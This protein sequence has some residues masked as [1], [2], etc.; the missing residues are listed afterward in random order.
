MKR[1]HI[2]LALI[3]ALVTL[4][5]VTCSSDTDR[6]PRSYPGGGDSARG[7]ARADDGLDV[8]PPAD[9][10]HDPQISPA[11]KLSNDQLGALDL[12]GKEQ[13]D[14]IMRLQRDSV[15]AAR[16]VR[17]VVEGNEPSVADITL[18]GQRLRGIR[19]V[20]F[21]R[22]I[23]MLAAERT[24]LTKEQW[25]T[26]Q[27]QIEAARNRSNRNSNGNSGRGRGGMGG[28]GRFPGM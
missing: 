28:R 7:V 5:L 14:E 15:V 23:Q 18:A 6:Q 8:M 2:A 22:R 12:I 1:T 20:L 11:V 3:L 21:D 13:G 19:D 26:L 10:W 9:W 16:D 17:Q 27:Q 25:M 4:A 24:L